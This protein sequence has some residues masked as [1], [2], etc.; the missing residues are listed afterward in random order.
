MQ[1]VELAPSMRPAGG[2]LDATGLVDRIEAGVGVRLERA[3]E[4]LQVPLGVL[5]LAVRCVGEPNRR[6]LPA[7]A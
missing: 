1:V 7:A 4:L 2:F 6:V 3:G 5:A